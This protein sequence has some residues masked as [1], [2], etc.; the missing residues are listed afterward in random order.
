MQEHL[1]LLGTTVRDKVSGL[2]GVVSSVSF[3]LT[4]IVSAAVQ[5]KY[6]EKEQKLP[7]GIW[8]PLQRLESTTAKAVM[9]VPV[10]GE[11]VIGKQR[12]A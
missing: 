2:T 8:M 12:A 10:F 6:D 7:S 1:K 11:P 4:G 3:D 5:P 9:P